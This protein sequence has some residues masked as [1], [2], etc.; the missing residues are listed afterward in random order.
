MSN[1]KLTKLEHFL[2]EYRRRKRI[3]VV[4]SLLS[5]LV[6]TATVVSLTLPAVT[7]SSICG[8]ET[9]VH[10]DECY[11]E[12]V[13]PGK[14][15]IVCGFE[16][17]ECTVLHTHDENCYDNDGNLICPLE[18]IEEHRH[19]EECYSIERVLVCDPD[20]YSKHTH[21]E[22][23]YE[24]Q[25][26]LKCG[27][28][29]LFAKTVLPDAADSAS[30][31][32]PAV[33]AHQHGEGCIHQDE[34]IVERVLVCELPEHVH[35][36]ECYPDEGTCCGIKAHTHTE[37]CFDENGALICQKQ[38]HRHTEECMTDRSDERIMGEPQN[39][40]K[41]IIELSGEAANGLSALLR[42]SADM[43]PVSADEIDM[44][45]FAAPAE[46]VPGKI[47][48]YLTEHKRE[49][50]TGYR[51]DVRLFHGDSMIQPT[52]EVT[53]VLSG[54]GNENDSRSLE[55]VLI[56]GGTEKAEPIPFRTDDGE[57]A[58]IAFETA[59]LS[60]LFVAFTKGSEDVPLRAYGAPG[61]IQTADSRADGIRIN[62]FDY[63]GYRLDTWDNKVTSPVYNGI[64]NGKNVNSDL[65]FL[66]TGS[67]SSSN[68]INHYTNGAIALQGIVNRTLSNGYP[69][70]RT[71]NSSLSYLFD[72]N[73]IQGAK[74]VYSDVN[75]LFRKDAEGY[76]RFDS[77]YNY[78]YYGS[79]SGGGNFTVYSN[80]YKNNDDTAIGFFPFNDYD[81]RYR[82]VKPNQPV[83]YNHHF[84]MTMS[85]SFFMPRG[86]MV[87][88]KDMIFDFSGDDDVWV[89]IDGVLVLDIGGI[90][91]AV[92]GQINFA[93]GVVTVEAATPA[94]CAGGQAIGTSSTLSAIFAAA[95][96]T[97]DGSDY[98]EHTMSFFYLERGGCYSNCS[99]TFNLN[100]YAMRELE[101]EKQLEGE[102]AGQFANNEFLFRL[103]I[104]NG[105]SIDD[106]EVFT[107]PAR[108]SDGT[109]VTFSQD[110]VFR[111][112][113]GQKIVASGIPDYKEYYIEELAVNEE[114]FPEVKIN[115]QFCQ[116]IYSGSNNAIYMIRSS[117]AS[118]R[119]RVEIVC[120]NVRP[121]PP[122]LSVE[123][124]WE[125]YNGSTINA[126][127]E[128]IDVQ[129]WRK[130]FVPAG[131]TSHTVRF[132]LLIYNASTQQ[133]APYFVH[134]QEV[135]HGG[136]ISFA[137]ALW[138][139]ASGAVSTG[140]P[141]TSNG[142]HAFE[143]W[144]NATV[145]VRNNV[146]QD[147]TVTIHY[148]VNGN[149]WLYA[150][151]VSGLRF[152]VVS[153]D[154][155]GPTDP[156]AGTFEHELVQ[157]VSL[158]AENGWVHEWSEYQLPAEHVSGEPYYY[159]VKEIS[160]PGY[161]TSYTNNNGITEGLI[162]ITNT[163]QTVSLTVIKSVVGTATG[164][165]FSFEAV[166][167]DGSGG[168]LTE[169][170][171]GTGYTVNSDGSVNFS[172]HDG[173]S[174]TISGLPRGTVATV[175]E[176]NH[177]G[178]VVLIKAGAQTLYTSDSGSIILNGDR[179]ITF[180]NSA[181]TVLPETG[182]EGSEFYIFGGYALM[183]IVVMYI[184]G[185]RI[186]EG[187]HS[188]GPY[189]D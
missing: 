146:T 152:H 43:F 167:E 68:G 71:N 104:G 41:E 107:G 119:D 161:E 166:F 36:D 65:L 97:F 131:G 175:T 123:K 9:H 100:V 23:C 99:L 52:G 101:I 155:P 60:G 184:L 153:C 122:K 96:R 106:Y 47:Q 21:T 32:L 147:E 3:A 180:V 2:K 14:K 163:M 34:P 42:G 87:N 84:G 139:S 145:F 70:L 130:H 169:I 138:V 165:S 77:D 11:E 57:K 172:L 125:S 83:H 124:L 17:A 76:Y 13:I 133:T 183:L 7:L 51:V 176:L 33:I 120:T 85:G 75:H 8:M 182:G 88:G 72:L 142:N 6:I 127:V 135:A 30:R 170:P 24:T 28:Q 92:H 164:D 185:R 98:S 50:L 74:T 156:S 117:I 55:N 140:G 62:L 91:E 1:E 144:L 15:R 12:R 128:S 31:A 56:L 171:S 22:E 102:D 154:E 118:I 38:E 116:P 10:G 129:L 20:E 103:F 162:R 58:G 79:N 173:E 26:V 110:G 159:Y 94:S 45:L 29:E 5:L 132:Q 46:E 186:R 105:S 151:Q 95:G 111:L 67:E 53:I 78:A 150:N 168:R 39:A 115:G 82:D 27:K 160:V 188:T 178:Y 179:E 158:S 48:S 114:Q 148:N 19:T 69:T 64:N 54:F 93:T 126:P 40:E 44:K 137:C 63:H 49:L 177:N 89:F 189:E 4:S 16:N 181:G 141:V 108:Y 18:E 121:K 109:A 113:A 37:E 136:S 35:T 134:S 174:V 59:Q 90:H 66:G 73:P 149:T 25:R 112:K 187:G 61:T 143:S 81:T 80:T 86:G 157:T